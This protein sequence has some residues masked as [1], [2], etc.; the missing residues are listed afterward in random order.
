MYMGVF[1]RNRYL[2]LVL[3][4]FTSLIGWYTL[5]LLTNDFDSD[6]LPVPNNDQVIGL[7]IGLFS[8]VVWWVQRCY[9]IQVRT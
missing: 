9:Q 3:M 2:A 5:L 7:C 4:M 1:N 8:T 6:V